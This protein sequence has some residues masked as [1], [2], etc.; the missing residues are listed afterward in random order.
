V[1]L[2]RRTLVVVAAVVAA[3]VTE[4]AGA[5]SPTFAQGLSSSVVDQTRASG[6]WVVI[7]RG[8]DSGSGAIAAAARHRVGHLAIRVRVTGK[9]KVASV[10]TAVLCGGEGVGSSNQHFTLRAQVVR[11]LRLPGGALNCGVT[12][13]A[14]TRAVVSRSGNEITVGEVAMELLHSP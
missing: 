5:A 7:G 14:T 6:H 9:P 12:A 8:Y 1:A 11:V 13:Y 2:S 4:G 10:W 3:W